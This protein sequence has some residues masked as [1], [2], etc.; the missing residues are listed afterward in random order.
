MTPLHQALWTQPKTSKA[1][2]PIYMPFYYV[3]PLWGELAR[4]YSRPG[5]S[6]KLE[7]ILWMQA[8]LQAAC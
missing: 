5:G 1:F 3:G 6:V 7:S 8:E 4:F 2:L